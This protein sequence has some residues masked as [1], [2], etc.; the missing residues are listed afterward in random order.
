MD[1]IT[2]KGM[3]FYGYHGCLPEERM[4][5]QPFH[6]DA[7][8]FVDAGKACASDDLEHTVDYGQVYRLVRSVVEGKPY[9]LIERLAAVIA[10][11]ILAQ[12]AVAAVNITVHKP[13]AP[14]GGFIDDVAVT[15]E[16][17]R[18]E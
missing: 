3:H 4:T 5:G 2:L 10:D 14:V 18:R 15:I 16:R 8:L 6:V 12:F 1:T 9:H 13:H 11:E 7:V 17:K